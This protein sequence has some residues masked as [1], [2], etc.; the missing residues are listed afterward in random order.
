MPN[1]GMPLI[2][3]NQRHVE[4]ISR[5]GLLIAP[6][7]AAIFAGCRGDGDQAMQATPPTRRQVRNADGESIDV[8]TLPQRVIAAD[9]T[10]LAHLLEL[11]VVPVA[12]GVPPTV[13][14]DGLP[15]HPSLAPLG[16]ADV[17]YY[18]RD[19]PDFEMILGKRP[20]L[21]V[22]AK[23]ILDPKPRYGEL[24]PAVSYISTGDRL[25]G[26]E[27]VAV[28]LGK[29]AEARDRIAGFR[30]RLADVAEQK[31]A[32]PTVS[33]F[34]TAPTGG[35]VVTNEAYWPAKLVATTLGVDVVPDLQ[36]TD[37]LVASSPG[38]VFVSPER[39]GQ[40]S[41]DALIVLEGPGGNAA[42]NANPVLQA[43]PAVRAG[44]VYYSDSYFVFG[45]SGSLGALADMVAEF[46][47]FLARP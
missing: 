42:F 17:T 7:A 19:E 6:L 16:A 22:G 8:P 5:R 27:A 28:I 15:Y 26:L 18:N 25:A 40:T 36:P 33:I 4:D 43:S 37:S 10:T 9:N 29:E 3:H 32:R 13:R 31:P 39:I 34:I 35:A 12:A 14:F 44:R 2:S 23:N 21:V 47:A 41:A 24:A 11:G 45:G 46:A 20:D 1:A 30:A 38:Y